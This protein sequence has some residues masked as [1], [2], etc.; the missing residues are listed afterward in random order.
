LQ[1]RARE[2]REVLQENVINAGGARINESIGEFNQPSA[3][4]FLNLAMEPPFPHYTEEIFG[5]DLL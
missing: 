2:T 1:V 4:I 3:G 5:Q